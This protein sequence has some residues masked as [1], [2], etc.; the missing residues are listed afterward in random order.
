M[1]KLDYADEYFIE[2]CTKRI[3]SI[4]PEFRPYFL[5]VSKDKT[6]LITAVDFPDGTFFFRVSEN[7]VSSAY[8]SVED[9]DRY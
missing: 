9:A 4:Y 2:A 8:N 7:S 5:G 1:Y 6:C 3:K